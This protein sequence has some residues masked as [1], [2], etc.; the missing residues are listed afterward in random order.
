MVSFGAQDVC[1]GF[2]SLE[3]WQA[4][5]DG[6]IDSMPATTQP[7]G[8]E[9]FVG[10]SPSQ[11]GG[12]TRQSRGREG[13]SLASKFLSTLLRPDESGHQL[14]SGGGSHFPHQK[15]LT[16]TDS[17][18]RLCLVPLWRQDTC[19][20]ERQQDSR[21]GNMKIFASLIAFILLLFFLLPGCSRSLVACPLPEA[22]PLGKFA[23]GDSR[24]IAV[25]E[26]MDYI[27]LR[28][29][30]SR[31]WSIVNEVHIH[32]GT[33]LDGVCINVLESKI[34]RIS[35]LPLKGNKSTELEIERL[36]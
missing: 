32:D 12:S 30:K 14:P 29:E 18:T 34:W 11:P 19:A 9:L 15:R 36:N 8:A 21:V 20:C 35:L 22:G 28:E 6:V 2:P 25:P 7:S 16:P 24:K 4:K 31:P 1:A 10:A 13:D 33:P 26:P 5:P 27:L 23:V 3:E 17:S